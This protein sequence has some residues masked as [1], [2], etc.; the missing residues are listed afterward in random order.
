[1]SLPGAQL[2][3]NTT[4][5]EAAAFSN[6]QTTH[7]PLC[8]KKDRSRYIDKVDQETINEAYDNA[9]RDNMPFIYSALE[10][11]VRR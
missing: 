5:F 7:L 4:I 10:P 2:I 8:Q 1:M 3:P 9:V 11:Y 6:P